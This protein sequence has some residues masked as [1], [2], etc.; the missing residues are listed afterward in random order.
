MSSGGRLYGEGQYGCAFMPPLRCKNKKKAIKND[1]IDGKP[2]DKITLKSEA[3]YEF[4][5]AKAVHQIPLWKNYFLV[6][7]SIC[8]PAA[9]Q[10]EKE[11][12]DCEPLAGKKLSDFR[13]LR[14]RY[15]GVPLVMYKIVPEVVPGFIDFVKHIIEAGALMNLFGI[16]HRDLHQGNILVDDEF[17]P[18]IIDFNYSVNVREKVQAADIRHKYTLL[19]FQEPPDSVLVNA[20]A[21]G[22]NGSRVIDNII[23]GKTILRKIQSILG[24]TLAEMESSLRSF[25]DKSVSAQAGDD[26]AWFTTYWRTVDSWAIG[27]NVIILIDNLIHMPQ[28]QAMW[29]QAPVKFTNVIRRFCAVSPLDRVDCVQALAH[30]D[31]NNF[32]VKKYAKQW[33]ERVG[34]GF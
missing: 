21:V 18:R 5:I 33:L 4:A 13:I 12:D 34:S 19:T 28:F 30:L 29:Q 7:E 32:I 22:H 31:P 9:V 24:I 23:R 26:V 14:L 15:G 10:V 11:L 27:V 2:I 6:S 20:I 25:Y 8:E 1:Q 16:V 3:E 17:V